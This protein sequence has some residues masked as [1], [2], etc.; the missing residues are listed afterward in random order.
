MNYSKIEKTIAGILIPIMFFGL[1]LKVPSF[2]FFLS[3]SA[4]EKK[5]HSIVS[6]LVDEKLYSWIK[7]SIEEYAWN[8]QGQLENTRVVII[9]TPTD[10]E[11]FKI[12]SLNE[13]LF[14][15]WYKW[16]KSSANFESK[17]IW[18]VL[19]GNINIPEVF[20]WEKSLKTILPYTD[21]IDKGYIYN[22]ETNRYEK[23]NNNIDWEKSEI[24]HWIIN[25]NTWNKGSDILAINNYFKKN[26]DFYKWT[27]N[28]KIENWIIN[29]NK[30]DEDIDDYKPYVF[31][32]DEYREQAGLSYTKYKWYESYLDNKE[33]LVYGRYSKDLA[34]R[35]KNSVLWA[36]KNEIKD[37]VSD[38]DSSIPFDKL[39]SWPDVST[40]SDISTRYVTNNSTKK[41]LEVVNSSLIWEFRKNVNNAG[42]YSQT[43]SKVNVDLIPHLVSVL[44]LIGDEII[45]WVN[46][47]LEVE[48]DKLVK[49][50]LSRDIAIPINIIEQNSYWVSSSYSCNNE[51]ENIL[52]WKQAR[53][54]SKASECSIY[55]WNTSNSWTLVEANRW[56]NIFNIKPDLDICKFWKTKWYW[57]GNS[58]VNLDKDLS[59]KWELRLSTHDLNSSIVPLFDILWSKKVEDSSKNPSPLDCLNNNFLVS[60]E[61]G[62]NWSWFCNTS[63]Q[64]PIN[65]KTAKNWNCSTTNKK[66][67]F[68]KDFVTMYKEAY[69]EICS[70][71]K[72]RLFLNSNLIKETTRPVF[73]ILDP[74]NN[75]LITQKYE[76]NYY[77]KNIP[78]YIEHK[79]PTFEELW[80][81]MKKPI[82]PNLP[83]D[84]NR[85]I[86]FI[87]AS[88]NYQKIFYPYLFR[89]N[90]NLSEIDN[91]EDKLNK[92]W[93]VLDSYLD[94]K[95]KEI[96]NIITSNDPSNLSWADLE[97]YNLLKNWNYPS[98]NFDLK[99]ILKSKTTKKLLQNNDSKNI[100]YYDML[101]F[102]MFWN[103]LTSIP[104][105]YKFIFENYLVDQFWNDS[106]YNLAKNKK[107]YEIAYLW[108]PWDAQNMYVKLDPESKGE[109]P[110][111]EINSKNISLNSKLFTSRV[112]ANNN[113]KNP[114][115]NCA[116]PEG[117]ILWEWMPAVMCRLDDI[118][119]PKQW[120]WS[121]RCSSET[122]FSDEDSYGNHNWDDETKEEEFC[123]AD[124]NRN[125][126]SDCIEID[127]EKSR[128]VLE[129]DN[130]KT[131][132][133]KTVNLKSSLV[134]E[135][136]LVFNSINWLYSDYELIKV[137]VKIDD[138]KD[139]D[140]NNKKTIFNLLSIEELSL[141]D[142][143]KY[144]KL[145]K[146][147]LEKV[148][149]YVSFREN[150]IRLNKWKSSYYFSVKNK[151]VN[152]YFRSV[153]RVL[154]IDR[155]EVDFR[156]SNLL[157]VKVRWELFSSITSNVWKW[158]KVEYSDAIISSE[159]LNV[160]LFDWNN[161]D[162]NI[163]N[164]LANW[165]NSKNKI[166]LSL[167]NYSKNNKKIPLNYPIE[168]SLLK[169]WNK[170]K[171]SQEI[172]KWDL[173]WV[174]WLYSLKES[175]EYK[176]IIKDYLWVSTF[177]NFRVL[178]EVV[179]DISLNLGTNILESKEV[180]TSNVI[181]L[182]DK[183]WN[184]ANWELYDIDLNIKWGWFV[185][186]SKNNEWTN[187]LFLKT[188]EWFKA[189]RLKTTNSPK[190]AL[191]DIKV[192]K[193][194][195]TIIQKNVNLQS[196]NNI[197]LKYSI[198]NN[199]KLVVWNNEYKINLEAL[200]EFWWKLNSRAYFTLD[201]KY[202]KL[203]KNYANIINWKAD[204][205][206]KTSTLAWKNIP[207]EIKVVWKKDIIKK[208]INIFPWKPMKIDLILSKT[209]MQ[210]S[211]SSISKLNVELKDRFNNLVFND[212]KTSFNVE[213]K[214]KYK[215]II[216]FDSLSKNSKNWIT[217]F[218]I[219]GTSS[220]WTAY[221]KVTTNPSL[222]NN[223]FTI[224]KWDKKKIIK[225]ISENAWKIQTYFFWDKNTFKNKKYNALYSVLLWA[226]YWDV[227]QKDYLAWSILFDKSN[228][229][230]VVTSMLNSPYKYNEII[231][232]GKR[233]A[234]TNVASWNDLSQNI[235]IRFWVDQNKKMYID[236][237]NKAL[238][239][240][241]WKVY[242][243]TSSN[244]LL[245]T[246]VSKWNDFSGCPVVSELSSI[247]I[248]SISKDYNVS[249]LWW[250][251]KF[252]NSDWDELFKINNLWEVSLNSLIDINVDLSNK[253]DY[254]VLN[255][256]K[257]WETIWKIALSIS[258]K[259]SFVS[260]NNNVTKAKL[261][262]SENIVLFSMDS[263]LYWTKIS[264]GNSLIYY[265]DP[266]KDNK[267]LNEFSKSNLFWLE[268]F[269]KEKS[270]G[271]WWENKFLLSFASW[272]NVWEATK[273]YISFWMINLWD[274]VI[275]LKKRKTK[276]NDNITEK[277]F[278]STIW[279]RLTNDDNIK[280]YQKFD[281]DKDN[282]EDIL[283]IKSDWYLKLLENKNN[284]FL[285]K[286]NLFYIADLWNS[287]FIKA[288]DFTWDWY[289]D[290]FLINNKW[291]PYILNNVSK[292]FIRIDLSEQFNFEWKVMQ[293]ESFDMDNDWLMDIVSLD[294]SW[295]I[296]IFYWWW[297]YNNPKFI[298][299][300]IWTWYWLTLNS[301]I[302]NSWWAIYFDWL[303]QINKR[304][305]TASTWSTMNEPFIDKLMFET[306]SY[307]KSIPKTAKERLVNNIPELTSSELWNT[308]ED[309][310]NALLSFYETNSWS[311]SVSSWNP[312]STRSFIRSEYSNI[313]WIQVE[314]K[315]IDINWWNLQSW[316]IVDVEV[317]I[318]NISTS[319]KNNIVYLD[320]V[321]SPF[322]SMANSLNTH[323]DFWEEWKAPSWYDLMFHKISLN[324][325]E[326]FKL[327]YKVSTRS[328]R[329][330]HIKVWLFEKED[331][332]WYDKFWD[333][334]IKPNNQNC[335]DDVEIFRSATSKSYVKWLQEPICDEDKLKLP[336]VL[337]K[338]K[339]D[340]NP[341]NG[342]PDY[343]D[344]ITQNIESQQE[345]A[346]NELNN[347]AKDTDWDWI[348]DLDDKSV[349]YNNNSLEN[350]FLENLDKINQSVDEISEDIDN[351]IQW[352]SCGFWWWSCI[353]TPLNW[354]PFLPW[355]D[356]T[357]M[358]YPA[359]DWL[360]VSEWLPIF[361]AMTNC[362]PVPGWCV[363]FVW[364]PIPWGWGWYLW[365]TYGL[366][367]LRINASI[368]L[369]WAAWMTFCYW[370]P[371][372]VAWN[373]IPMWL[374]PI[375]PYWNCMV[376]AK[377]LIGCSNSWEDWDPES[378][379]RANIYWEWENSF[380]VLNWNCEKIAKKESINLNKEFLE[381]YYSYKLKKKKGLILSE[382]EKKWLEEKYKKEMKK[383]SWED[384]MSYQERHNNQLLD[385]N[386]NTWPLFSFNEWK[387]SES[388]LEVDLDLSSSWGDNFEDVL[389]I[390][391][392]RVSSFPFVFM[393]W[394]T[395]Q[396]ENII[397]QLTDLPTLYVILPDFSWIW[398]IS[399]WVDSEKYQETYNKWV[400]K[401]KN[402]KNN[403]TQN[404]QNIKK[405]REDLWCD[406]STNIT[407]YKWE[408]ASLKVN[409]INKQMELKASPVKES[410]SWIRQVYEFLWNIPLV[411][412]SPQ[413]VNVDIPWVTERTIDKTISDWRFAVKQYEEEYEDWKNMPA[414]IDAWINTNIWEFIWNINRNIETLE[415]YKKF[416]DKLSELLNK[417]NIRLE[418]VLCNVESISELTGAWIWFNWKRFK[419]WVETYILIKAILKSWQMLI[420]IFNDYEAE[421]HECKNER[422]DLLNYQ[423]EIISM[424]MPKFAPIKFPKWPDIILD[425]HNIRA[426]LTIMVP[427]V[428]INMRPIILPTLPTLTL[429]R[430]NISADLNLN[431]PN[432]P[433]LPRFEIP[434]LPD[435]PGLPS[436]ELP[437]L[438]PP[439]QLPKLFP[440]LEGVL[441]ILKLITKVM[442]ILKTSPY[443]PEW[444]AWDQVAFLTERNWTLPFDFLD[445]STTLPS[446][447][448]D[449]AIK[450]TTFVNLEFET[451]F[452][453]ELVRQAV[454]PVNSI[455][456]NVLNTFSNAWLD[457]LDFSKYDVNID[458]EADI[459]ASWVFDWKKIETDSEW[460]IHS[461]WLKI[462]ESTSLLD[463]TK[464]I[465]K[466]ITNNYNYIESNKNETVDSSEF[467]SLVNNYLSK[468]VLNWD[469]NTDELVLLWDSVNK[470]DYEKENKL[471]SDLQKNN[472]EKF[473]AVKD[474]LNNEIRKTNKIKVDLKKSLEEWPKLFNK[475]SEIN[476]WNKDFVEYKNTLDKYNNSFIEATKNLITWSEDE[477][478]KEIKKEW[479][480]ILTRVETWINNFKDSLSTEGLSPLLAQTWNNT[481]TATQNS[482]QQANNS[483][484]KYKYEWLYIVEKDK[485]YRLF[486]YLDE[487]NWDEITTSIDF[488]WDLDNDLLYFTDWNLYLKE[489][490]QKKSE[491][492]YNPSFITVDISDNKFFRELFNFTEA[493]NWFK[494]V[495]TDIN[496][497]NVSFN[498]PTNKKINHF[499]LEYYS[500]V[501][502]FLNEKNNSYLPKDIYKNI[503]DS[504][505]DF[506]HDELLNL[507]QNIKHQVYI[508]YVWNIPWVRLTTKKMEN[509]KNKKNIVITSGNRI[510]TAINW[511]KIK[512][513]I[514][515]DDTKYFE[516]EINPN[517]S[518]S[519]DENIS[520]SNINWDIYVN[521][522]ENIDLVWSDE[523]RSYIW[524]PLFSETEI[525]VI[526]DFRNK[527]NET[528]HIELM[529]S[530]W[531]KV[532][533][534]FNEINSYKIYDLWTKS[535]DYLIKIDTPNDFYYSK[536]YAIDNWIKWTY[537]RQVVLSP[538]KEADDVSPELNF[539]GK[540]RIPVYQK[541][542]IDFT[543]NIYDNSWISWISSINL[544]FNLDVDTDWD[545]NPKNDMDSEFVKIN[546]TNSSVTMEFW[547][548]ND[549]IDKKIWLTL[550]DKN[551]NKSFKE[552]DFE[553]YAPV[554]NIESVTNWV[555][556]WYIN[557]DIS[558]EPINIYR[559]RWWVITKI[560]DKNSWEK[561]DTIDAWLFSFNIDESLNWLII[562]DNNRT[563]AN[564]DEFT[565]K[566]NLKWS[567]WYYLWI[568]KDSSY[569]P[570]FVIYNSS[571]NKVYSQYIKLLEN[572][573]ISLISDISNLDK[574]WIYLQLLN[575][576]D[577][578]YYKVPTW[579]S[580]SPWTMVIYKKSDINKNP[581]FIIFPDWRIKVEDNRY[582][583]IYRD[584]KNNI[585]LTFISKVWN[586]KIAD[587]LYNVE[588]SYLM[589]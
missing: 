426:G 40:T 11:S 168:V 269:E 195:K 297:T 221:F 543:N 240:Y 345:Y 183:F 278:D 225:W 540:I 482:C 494:E 395:E 220:P 128:L 336:D 279:K 466:A 145:K 19:I 331:E 287:D 244:T 210:A 565:W 109:N 174:T 427:D 20:K 126:I 425:L 232:I 315:Y 34:E 76:K 30:S 530:D 282:K 58:P 153:V 191:I 65:W 207:L 533:L 493:I 296:N 367:F 376:V 539:F 365:T 212:N 82:T 553:V 443:V 384:N 548:F 164:R 88:W 352:F 182:K 520:I 198:E 563:I 350:K 421:C 577:Y 391:Q 502:K 206:I 324:S 196:I 223:A 256:E 72:K 239:T 245:R 317:N 585:W 557:E 586:K 16:L 515:E 62:Y 399:W 291:N 465:A 578:S 496:S 338:N 133:N 15:E 424:I 148:R 299:N 454:E 333:I 303:Y 121:S 326:N 531:N 114:V 300:N 501:D 432:V 57:W 267:E 332:V 192:K 378:M 200:W 503:I 353:T 92:V 417:K 423:F 242:Y 525:D 248:K 463:F 276:F 270:I 43:G 261:D 538:Q 130:E 380:W 479:E 32:F 414:V 286:W 435:L 158:W 226:E 235:D 139:L 6:L 310:K 572:R 217:N 396:F 472:K 197:D 445:L 566:I 247:F 511:A 464:I 377:P 135:D 233:W 559:L 176:I 264:K 157:E 68:K 522:G 104:Q 449:D 536:I 508:N 524:L 257:L 355:Q 328:F 49:N 9:P 526:P 188:F 422:W 181:L 407:E 505:V 137:D 75:C 166:L 50:G 389:K 468:I 490:L 162:T 64:L 452:L 569:Y 3:W 504:F 408:C 272:E 144:D 485:S 284:K 416:P 262:N 475:V 154:D 216:K 201:P 263:Y 142:K 213:L 172:Y 185:F 325:W 415:E 251:L 97:I 558:K 337:E 42:R 36:E 418:Q 69:W 258:D 554:P 80:A 547:K 237:Y 53:D 138:K 340:I 215:K 250:N 361:S 89:I 457:I 437:N 455:T 295:T 430:T 125:W 209:K 214:D 441:K 450:V 527:F 571:W 499:R 205:I 102:S 27:W 141:N 488:D 322:K 433:L 346:R 474:I 236:F 161:D 564:V 26:N 459:D 186:P 542:T 579:L 359:W 347:L 288:W 364:P 132:Y 318:K 312:T 329:I 112:W 224:W 33:D 500:I 535:S 55:R 341:K 507:G 289:D 24:W 489:N 170:I 561:V 584:Y 363:P 471:I 5:L 587:L 28:F 271:W 373:S 570:K 581:I 529:Y 105:K 189:F 323:K 229:N 44:D 252:L 562:K 583:I 306:V 147:W 163:F 523:L 362:L 173:S 98:S 298:K 193:D 127:F 550:L 460:S 110:Y 551:W 467:L 124:N 23:N 497:I 516:K 401:Q 12:S 410:M 512:Y 66:N 532:G 155:K 509:I 546:K 369:T 103:S 93:E 406:Q 412:V 4:G 171:E 290:I 440:N 115:F 17:L 393:D 285:D 394:I 568:E 293:L 129:T 202:W 29:W 266:F 241:I 481:N 476:S 574:K 588:W 528:S 150:K 47:D 451:E 344:D 388:S 259:K 470:Y 309:T 436:I 316:D 218:N 301:N 556:S 302:R 510:Y 194:S 519:F 419:A 382:S 118:L 314:K 219:S 484:Y 541:K 46:N 351:L 54:I 277:S 400:E 230:L 404:I 517:S 74:L 243:K 514:W 356:P 480:K 371:A 35:I 178:P 146:E 99:N 387:I 1:I 368:T 180:I 160:F 265:K 275:S 552:L 45:K 56:L 448:S 495:N 177:K 238:N 492:L 573:E 90:E 140:E 392:K 386:W 549:L 582:D 41:F 381:K 203:N 39:S 83:I 71:T 335:S 7:S 461:D 462:D 190:S 22:H 18:T 52:F 254:L 478:I 411:A 576:W 31:Y 409:L 339:I 372:E 506:E 25:P 446:F 366:N 167:L 86:D 38:L 187:N 348:P 123:W 149:K 107:I 483:D 534:N 111:A 13:S 94:D 308:S 477:E 67:E 249:S 491:K 321:E 402:A 179:D 320:K 96:N 434:E 281:Y 77:F 131:D 87:W 420:D 357:F 165:S 383:I 319:R 545:W 390:T 119:P 330:G 442:C 101:V 246:C 403:I 280:S 260:R 575:T 428:N 343:I 120:F 122:L 349:N 453:T 2:D 274:P 14:Y 498:S 521:T 292:D 444:R 304:D 143:E 307:W 438:P 413:Q 152:L 398:T 113:S 136:W 580:Y 151:D 360:K 283:L 397:I 169:D 84:K 208:Y 439:F 159:D 199:K 70:D 358:W 268:N 106:E 342:I 73:D 60:E 175:W 81:Q 48:I 234:L 429:P 458:V 231:N 313:A 456:N 37:L 513:Y 117:V 374:S 204:I 273:K 91:L 537:S 560:E 100:S 518:I 184:I 61:Q 116:P 405:Q 305:Y 95:S 311:V 379:W 327:N 21:F 134:N 211:N 59:G 222:E 294:D 255:I 486:N 334:I 51:Y 447:P 487:L 108:A 567:F 473:E 375:V 354:A 63:Y 227:T 370:W 544:D 156:Y 78:S 555:V 79:S 253:E 8:I 431:L 469:S 228:R 589:K 10:A 85:Y 385:K